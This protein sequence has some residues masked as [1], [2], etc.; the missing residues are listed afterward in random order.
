MRFPTF[1]PTDAT[2]PLGILLLRVSL[3]VMSISHGFM[4][5]FLLTIPG[6]V[7][8]FENVGFP[9]WFAYPT[10]FA[11]IVCGILLVIGVMPRLMALLLLPIQFGALT[12]H[13][14]NGWIFTNQGGGWEYPAFLVI[15]ALA[16]VLLGDGPFTLLRTPDKP[17]P[18]K[19]TE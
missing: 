1:P 3:G 19:P 16:L 7:A 15:V 17:R 9:G 14:G 18:Y 12:V 11:E 2:L 10:L 13:Y 4:K 8:F 5:I 6:T